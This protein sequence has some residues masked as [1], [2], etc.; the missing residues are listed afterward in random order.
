MYKSGSQ[1]VR[2][3]VYG[4]K[5]DASV[6]EGILKGMCSLVNMVGGWV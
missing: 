3:A 6:F 1:S 4:C 5:H 2:V